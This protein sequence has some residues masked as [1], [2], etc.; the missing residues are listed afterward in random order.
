MQCGAEARIRDP[1]ARV[2][3]GPEPPDTD[4]GN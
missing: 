1:R 4:A 3:F 2:T